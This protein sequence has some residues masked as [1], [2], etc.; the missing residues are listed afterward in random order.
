MVNFLHL[1]RK[2]GIPHA[3]RF[4]A[5]FIFALFLRI[6]QTLQWNTFRGVLIFSPSQPHRTPLSMKS[7]CL[8]SLPNKSIYL[9]IASNASPIWLVLPTLPPTHH[10]FHLAGMM[11]PWQ[12]FRGVHDVTGMFLELS[13]REQCDASAHS[14]RFLFF[15]LPMMKTYSKRD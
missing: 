3:H 7:K 10:H 13:P 12:H 9:G 14:P 6:L 1:H 2:D 11:G 4:I 8:S 15:S 5:H